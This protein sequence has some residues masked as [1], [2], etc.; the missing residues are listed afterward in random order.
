MKVAVVPYLSRNGRECCEISLTNRNGM[1]VK[2]LNYGATLEQVLLPIGEGRQENVVLSLESPAAYSAERNFLGGTVGRVLGRIK[3][4]QWQLGQMTRQFG[5]NDGVNHAHG[6]PEGFDTQV[7]SFAITQSAL[8]TTVTMTLFDPAWHNGYPGNMKVTVRYSFDDRD[9]LTY[10]I[11]A[12]SDAV[13]LCNPGNHTCFRL[14]GPQQSAT[15]DWL[16]LNAAHYLPLD[17]DSIPTGH[18]VAVA[19][20]PFDFRRLKQIQDAL[21]F[22]DQ[23][24]FSENGL[25]HPF[26]LSG[27]APAAVLTSADKKRRMTMTTNAPAIIVYTAN[28]FNHT[29]VAHNIGRYDGVALEAQV[30]PSRDPTLQA[31]T[32]LPQEPFNRLVTWQFEY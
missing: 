15:A 32:L 17:A 18:R 9:R 22:Q 21:D 3:A 14:S 26:L 13:T 29:G 23:Q 31:I 4:G 1:T 5:L 10:Q 27:T 11:N 6:G 25:N 30:P 19:G 12:V 20:T 28:H 16:Q 7:F 8:N 24:I 2:L